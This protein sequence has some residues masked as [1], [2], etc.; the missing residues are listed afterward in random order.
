MKIFDAAAKVDGGE[1]QIEQ[2]AA[3]IS[4][5]KLLTREFRL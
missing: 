1:V 4:A 2:L 5:D 3:T